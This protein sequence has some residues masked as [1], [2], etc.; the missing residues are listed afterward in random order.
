[1]TTMKLLKAGI[2]CLAMGAALSGCDEDDLPA[3]AAPP[4][5]QPG[6]AAP[7]TFLVR[8]ENVSNS[9]TLSIPG[10]SKAVPLSPGAY[11]V[12]RDRDLLFEP[13]Q[14]ASEGIER[15]A[16]DGMPA[17]LASALGA[18][19]D[20]SSSGVF[21][22]A[23]GLPSSTT[24]PI[25]PGE[26]YEFTVSGAQPGDRLSLA[27]MFAES[28]DWFYATPSA[29]VP[30]F[31]GDDGGTPISGDLTP[32]IGLW[33][34][35]TERDEVIGVGLNQA[36][37][38]GNPDT[39]ALD[40]DSVIQAVLVPGVMSMADFADSAP[41]TATVLKVTVQAQ[42]A[43]TTVVPPPPEMPANSGGGGHGD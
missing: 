23:M 29:G 36:P 40:E 38:Q 11:A 17:A 7:G 34:A 15:I 13:G 22:Q 31:A 24:G 2:F 4:S 41:G 33:D 14:P 3:G 18:D 16:E 43:A 21:N 37:R 8:I 25:H 39:G 1:M 9:M 6:T 32:Q 42:G 20:L 12:H 19:R 26:F 10:G 27:F 35:G 30:L 5:Q 28:N